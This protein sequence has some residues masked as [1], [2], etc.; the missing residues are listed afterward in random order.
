M[1]V[2]ACGLFASLVA[3]SACVPARGRLYVRVGPPAPVVEARIIAPG[4]GYVWVPGYYFW[5]GAQYVWR[6]GVWIRPP[7]GR[8]VWVPGHW[9]NEGRRGW[10]WIDGHWR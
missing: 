1:C 5:S 9:V 6:P 8:G 10:F 7:R 3:A 2:A 4:P